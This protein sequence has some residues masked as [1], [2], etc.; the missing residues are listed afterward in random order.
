MS[1]RNVKISKPNGTMWKCEVTDSHGNTHVNY[2]ETA[3]EAS[4]WTYYVWEN[5]ENKVDKD[6]LM[7]K[8]ILE[9]I[10]TDREAG[11]TS[12]YRDCLD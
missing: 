6:D 2:W 10:E 1:K 4:K 8:A 5:E 9:C 3:E 11:I 12:E 7:A